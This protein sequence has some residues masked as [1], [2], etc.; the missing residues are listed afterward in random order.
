MQESLFAINN[1]K[2]FEV[3]YIGSLGVNSWT[4]LLKLK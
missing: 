1:T 2:K 3:V 4:Y